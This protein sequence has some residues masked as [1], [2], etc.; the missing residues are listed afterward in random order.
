[1]QFIT[2]KYFPLA[3]CFFSWDFQAGEMISFVFIF[4]GKHHVHK[5]DG[6]GEGTSHCKYMNVELIEGGSFVFEGDIGKK[7]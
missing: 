1:M 5:R 2:L 6:E 3:L 4:Q 7:Q